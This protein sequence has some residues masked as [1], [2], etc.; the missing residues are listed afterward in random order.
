MIAATLVREAWRAAAPGGEAARLVLATCTA[1][2]ITGERRPTVQALQHLLREALEHAPAGGTITAR[3]RR[4]GGRRSLEIGVEAATGSED[5]S[6]AQGHT[7]SQ[8]GRGEACDPRSSLRV[9][10]ARLLLE[11]QGARVVVTSD[12]RE[13][14]RAVVEFPAQG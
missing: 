7:G 1:C 10:L 13:G 5:S 14:W 6:C 9:I 8:H 4:Q 2:D 3:G 12:A 11:M